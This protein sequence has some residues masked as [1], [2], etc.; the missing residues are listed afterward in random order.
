M[1]A[2]STEKLRSASRDWTSTTRVLDGHRLG[3]RAELEGDDAERQAIGG[4]DDDVGC[5]TVLNESIVT[6]RL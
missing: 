5:S 4:V 6:F 2:E 1:A 3:H